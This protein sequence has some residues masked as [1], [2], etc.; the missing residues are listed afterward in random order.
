M[1]SYERDLKSI[2]NRMAAFLIAVMVLLLFQAC[3]NQPLQPS[4]HIQGTITV[5]STL[6][7]TKDYSGIEL[8]IVARDTTIQAA[9]TLFFATTS[10]EGYF[11]GEITFPEQ[12]R[13]PL[14]INRNENRVATSSIILAPDDSV[15]ISGE[16]PN[17]S[18]TKD[19][20]SHEH[21]A[22]ETY[23]RVLKNFNRLRQ[24]VASEGLSGDTLRQ[25]LIKWSDLF[26]DVRERYD[27]TLGSKMAALQSAQLLEEW[28][29]SLM[30]KRLSRIESDPSVIEGVSRLG[31]G[32]RARMRGLDASISYLDSI[33]QFAEK[34]ENRLSIDLQQL[35]MLID[36]S[37]VDAA[38]RELQQMADNYVTGTNPP[39]WFTYYKYELDNLAPG[40]KFPKFSFRSL[41]GDSLRF[42]VDMKGPYL[43]E[44]T[45]VANRTYMDQYD[46]MFAIHTVYNSGGLNLVT[47]PLDTSRIT[48]Q[49]FYEERQRNWPVVRPNSFDAKSLIDTLNIRSVPTRF[50]VDSQGRLVRKYVGRE[51]DE[52]VTELQTVLKDTEVSL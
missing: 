23:Q 7:D 15:T 18:S 6:D 29:D 4:T 16:L 14:L 2:E 28:N 33:Q 38:R 25:E 1:N 52:V 48:V 21:E 46:K 40:A 10:R 36:S 45:S 17:F 20:E 44:I 43:L 32:A 11:E 19:I 12:A 41:D 49:A 34:R 31:K 39:D 5:D 50:L 42:G 47:V 30:V 51:I 26:W 8:A 13:Y 37:K 35:E 9:D 3:S 22:F 24:Y 27:G